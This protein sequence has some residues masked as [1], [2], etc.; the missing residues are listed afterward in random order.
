MVDPNIRPALIEDRG[1]YLR[2]FERLAASSRPR[3]AQRCR[4]LVAL[5][6]P[7]LTGRR[8]RRRLL[9]S[10]SRG[11]SCS[12][13]ARHG[14]EGWTA[15]GSARVTAPDCDGRR[16]RREP[17]DAFG[18]GLLAWLWRF[19]RLDKLAVRHLGA[20]RARGSPHVRRRSRSGAMHPRLGMGARRRPT[21]TACLT[22]PARPR[23]HHERKRL[24]S[25]EFDEVSKIY[26]ADVWAVHDLT[27]TVHHGEFV[28]LVGPSGCGKTTALRMLAGLEQI[29][30]GEIRDRR[31]ARQRNAHRASVTSRWSFR[32]MRCIHT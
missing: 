30:A 10:G 28:V 6:R 4:P 24:A 32:T 18:A 19:N 31:S 22:E 26:G 17:G 29:T 2:R 8:R 3:E 20:T 16:H 5:P 12:R 21:S 13:T 1:T 11:A 14:A 9:G 7:K 27:L 23:V 15:S 25:L